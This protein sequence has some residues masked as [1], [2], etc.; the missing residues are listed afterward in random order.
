MEIH[1]DLGVLKFE[2]FFN[3]SICYYY[4][5]FLYAEMDD[6]QFVRN[7]EQLQCIQTFLSTSASDLEHVKQLNEVCL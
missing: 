3:L 2:H 1:I 5:S 7:F 4:E 6:V